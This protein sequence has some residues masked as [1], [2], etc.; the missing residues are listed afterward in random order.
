MRQVRVFPSPVTGRPALRLRAES[1]PVVFGSSPDA[2]ARLVSADGGVL[3][4][5]SSRAGRIFVERNEV[6]LENISR[7]HGLM[8]RRW[9][10]SEVNDIELPRRR[11]GTIVVTL[12]P[13]L[14]WIRNGRSHTRSGAERQPF[15]GEVC[16]LLVDIA[17]ADDEAPAADPG[18]TSPLYERPATAPR[19]R[20]T[21]AQL[22]AVA[23]IFCEYLS[24]PP[25]IHPVMQTDVMLREQMG[26][27]L[28]Q[29][30]SEI[31]RFAHANGFTGGAVDA[32]L[33]AW[34]LAEGFVSLELLSALPEV[35]HLLAIPADRG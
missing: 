21:E 10:H 35:R 18:G 24:F 30:R 25:R 2:E 5:V 11:E 7:S 1:R 31:K 14:W 3:P 22:K 32:Q 23:A 4:H 8:C 6:Y 16:W 26:A 27:G 19:P 12:T 15:D 33:L 13:G 29:R 17:D 34:L 20:L 9:G 28:S